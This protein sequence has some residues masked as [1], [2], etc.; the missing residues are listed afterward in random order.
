MTSILLEPP[1]GAW[2]PPRRAAEL[3][4]EVASWRR[5]TLAGLDLNAGDVIVATGHQA[6]IWH[7]GIL[8]KDLAATVVTARTIEA[9][10]TATAIHFIAD[11]DAN[12]AGL[13][14]LPILDERNRLSSIAWRWCPSSTARSTRDRPA[15]SPSP[16][17]IIRPPIPDLT[18]R[19][20]AIHDAL[21]THADQ[22]SLAWQVGLAAATLSQPIVGELPRRSM[23]GLLAL[24]VGDAILERIRRDPEACVRA[25]DDAVEADRDRRARGGRRP[26]GMA[27][28]LGRGP[29]LE[30]PL[31]FADEDGRRPATPADLVTPHALRPRALLATALA[32][33]GGCDL[34]IHGTGGGVYDFVMEDWIARWLGP[35]IA[36][37]LAPATVASATCRLDLPVDA[38]TDPVTPEDL[39]RMR[40]DPDL[41]RT[42]DEAPIRES[43]L[44]AID[45]APRRSRARRIAFER[46]HEA[47]GTARTRGAGILDEAASRLATQH[48][49]RRSNE[50]AT[51]RTWAFP[52]HDEA[53]LEDL[54]GRIENAWPPR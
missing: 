20:E 25:H 30:L 39:H 19:V 33:L 3:A 45:A 10:T 22:P 44:A 14:R 12:D 47:I 4:T 29:T 23:S 54:R 51:D 2:P 53:T 46:L 18:D 52:L 6:A 13:I 40:F 11:H 1:A 48:A 37:E 36:D 34:F 35:E 24:P 27:S 26:R 50:L 8:A 21:A 43:L 9:G 16:P 7:A 15:A 17:P 49:T 28:L 5:E 32:R 38:I 42:L 31:W 41:G